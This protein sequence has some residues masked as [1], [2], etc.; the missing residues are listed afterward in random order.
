[1]SRSSN[2]AEVKTP[3]ARL[4]AVFYLLWSKDPEGYKEFERYYDS[5]MELLIDHYK[6]IL[7]NNVKKVAKKK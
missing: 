5:K 1:M 2:N 3:S 6:K 4:R 7:R